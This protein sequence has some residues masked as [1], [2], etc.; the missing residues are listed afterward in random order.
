MTAQKKDKLINIIKVSLGVSCI[1]IGLVLVGYNFYLN[2]QIKKNLAEKLN[3]AVTIT[4]PAEKLV[5]PE[6]IESL[7]D[8]QT[9]DDVIAYTSV[10]EIPKINV[11]VRI[12][13]GIDSYSLLTGVGRYTQTARLCENGTT[14][15]AG[16]SSDTYDCI[17]ND[18]F[19]LQIGDNFFIYDLDGNKHTYYVTQTFTCSPYYTEILNNDPSIGINR[20]MLFCCT[21]KGHDRY[22]VEGYEFTEEQWLDYLANLS[23]TRSAF[24]DNLLNSYIIENIT[25]ELDV[26]RVEKARTFKR[27]V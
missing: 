3:D 24:V 20:T 21:N 23:A 25:K 27:G 13:D 1:V 22:M 11:T 19:D 16:H 5:N 15:I 7:T 8:N 4:K 6:S 10:L 17:F 26:F 2:T 9:V 14:V 12:N 18:L